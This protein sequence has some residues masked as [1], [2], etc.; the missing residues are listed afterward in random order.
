MN[1]GRETGLSQD[2]IGSTTSSVSSTLHGDTNVGTREGGSIVGTITSHGAKMTETLKT[3]NDLVLVLGEDT[4]ETISI[5]DHLVEGG[6]LAAG[7]RSVLQD[8]GG[9]HVVAQTETA[10]SFLGNGKLITG[11]HLDLDTKSHSIVNGLF[12]ILA[13]RIEDGEE[14]DEFE[15]IALSLVIITL[16][17]LKSDSKGT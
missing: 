2:D 13:G 6:M 3:L 15:T 16:D 4:G 14:T 11:D 7:G 17:F 8:L 10:S 12:G 1:D 9:I 5:Q